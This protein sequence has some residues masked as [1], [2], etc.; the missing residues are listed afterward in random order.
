MTES[1]RIERDMSR[2]GWDTS[3]RGRK[4]LEGKN[5]EE[6]VLAGNVM[7]RK[8]EGAQLHRG[9]CS[10]PPHN[11]SVQKRQIECESEL[12]SISKPG[13]VIST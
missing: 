7:V 3:A 5:R 8:I 6:M 13:F 1:R 9:T 4:A 10:S 12:T 2:S 11:R